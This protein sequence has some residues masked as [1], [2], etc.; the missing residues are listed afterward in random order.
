MKKH[1]RL[2]GNILASLVMLFSTIVAIPSTANA[3]ASTN[4]LPDNAAFQQQTS[5]SGISITPR[6]NAII[7]PGKS[8]TG[9]LIIGNLDT[10]ASLYLKLR[11][12]DFTYTGDTGEPK[13]YTGNQAQTPWSLKPYIK[14]PSNVTIGPGDSVSVKYTI[15]I[16]AGLGAGSYYSAIEY[17]SGL[18]D[19]GNVGLLSSGVTLVFVSVSGADHEKLTLERFGAYV[20]PNSGQTGKFKYFSTTM[21]TMMAFKLKNSGNVAEAPA[22]TIIIKKWGHA[23]KTIGS[24]NPDSLLDLI[25]QTRLFTTCLKSQAEVGKFAPDGTP[26][27][28]TTCV[29]PH[30]FP[31]HYSATLEAFY[32]QNGNPSQEVV[33]TA[34]F[35]YIPEWLLIVLIVIFLVIIYIIWRIY[36]KI[37]K[38]IGKDKSSKHTAAHSYSQRP[39]SKKKSKLKIRRG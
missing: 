35:W 32:G 13:L 18:G 14:L 5:S 39:Q 6:A 10:T 2:F 9:T 4:T 27:S 15:T 36:R 34:G 37:R 16:P 33:G 3:T 17:E 29:N 11:V 23:Y 12:I 19:Q 31:G 20:S 26:A 1:I 28:A 25:G 21:P 38:M 7:D 30:L 24:V 8:A 22:G